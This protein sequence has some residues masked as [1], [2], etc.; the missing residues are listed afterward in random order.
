M[1]YEYPR[2]GSSLGETYLGT[3]TIDGVLVHH[4]QSC[5][6]W[7]DDKDNFTLDYYFTTS[8]WIPIDPNSPRQIPVRAVV[9]GIKDTGQ[10]TTYKFNHVY[11]YLNFRVFP[12][13]PEE[14]F[15]L[16]VNMKC[17]DTKGL[18]K[19]VM[20]SLPVRMSYTVEIV[21]ED[22]A[23]KMVDVFYDEDRRLVRSSEKYVI[24][25]DDF[26]TGIHYT[27]DKM[28]HNC[29]VRPIATETDN[30]A[31]SS[32][33]FVRMK[34]REEL[35][36]LDGDFTY[37]GQLDMRGVPCDAWVSMK[38]LEE[39]PSNVQVYFSL[40]S[41]NFG[42][43]KVSGQKLLSL[44][45][46]NN[47]NVTTYNFF[48][49]VL[50]PDIST[51]PFDISMCRNES[52]KLDFRLVLSYT[53]NTVFQPHT[54]DSLI[55]A[56]LSSLIVNFTGVSF[57][58]VE[59]SDIEWDQVNSQLH[60]LGSIMEPDPLFLRAPVA[61]KSLPVS[62]TQALA[63]LQQ[64]IN[65]GTFVVT[66]DLAA[67]GQAGS[68][69]LDLTALEIRATSNGVDFADNSDIS[70]GQFTVYS[71]TRI[72]NYTPN[73]NM[74]AVSALSCADICVDR[75]IY[76]C[77]SFTYCFQAKRCQLSS[78]RW[79][80][81][82]LADYVGCDFYRRE[83]TS[84]FMKIPGQTI[85]PTNEEA[86]HGVTSAEICASL[87]LNETQFIC[88]SFDYCSASQNCYLSRYHFYGASPSDVQSSSSCDHY[89]RN[90]VSDYV[91]TSATA[92]APKDS[93]QTPITIV[94]DSSAKECA[95]MCSKDVSDCVRFSF[96]ASTHDC[97]MVTKSLL[98]FIPVQPYP[99]CDVYT[100]RTSQS[101]A[102]PGSSTAAPNPTTN[103]P[104]R[105]TSD[106]S[107]R[108]SNITYSPGSM[109]GLAIA[110]IVVGIIACLTTVALLRRFN[111]LSPF[112]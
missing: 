22:N 103:E 21:G 50:N 69:M 52:S 30:D 81:A 92:L 67:G 108:S 89:S 20:P 85:R 31:V 86:T 64:Q 79:N 45:V 105:N 56:A 57:L 43:S 26:N 25:I 49:E 62:A 32:A 101:T 71:N 6:Y 106:R 23:V 16:P 48:N 78:Q 37:T 19:K 18:K 36:F 46:S 97:Q 94:A 39:C 5:M 99:D 1:F 13:L 68:V 96:C 17:E 53:S 91:K 38:V 72:L 7:S 4:W 12:K 9:T 41:E 100:L 10:S 95:Y 59:W 24:N 74:F 83:S 63:I 8:D 51:N 107:S 75:S 35:F 82:T 110:M 102:T 34:S 88:Q 47:C 80:N 11:E 70:L 84:D 66:I 60:W 65:N 42:D 2:F 44:V 29:S 98:P 73:E 61:N 109:A 3:A 93:S 54:Q 55:H 76:E 28:K 104:R 58:R 87:C 112:S 77:R 33:H 40:K 27:V 14:I 15:A 90:Y 111:I